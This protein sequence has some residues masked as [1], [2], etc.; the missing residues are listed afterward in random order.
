MALHLALEE[1]VG[2]L[3]EKQAELLVAAREDADRLHRI[4]E[5]LLEMGRIRS[6]RVLMDLRPLFPEDLVSQGMEGMR[7]SFRDKGVTLESDVPGDAPPVLADTI[8]IGLVVSNL[9]GNALKFT[10]P[11]GSVTV[12]V[13]S[14]EREQGKEVVFTVQDTGVGIPPESLPHLFERFYR[15][16]GQEEK[17]GAGLGLAIAKEIVEA[18]GGRVWAESEIGR[19][20]RFSFALRAA[21]TKQVPAG[22]KT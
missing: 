1:R 15:V 21:E 18:H 9:L 12:S 22:P 14:E 19:G 11:G 2:P 7:A 6:G 13:R 20:S 8:R 4:I 16:P 10:P 3:N 5:G 17:S